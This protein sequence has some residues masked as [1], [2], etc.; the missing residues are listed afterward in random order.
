[1]TSTP[2]VETPLPISGLGIQR[3]VILKPGKDDLQF[4][5]ALDMTA[6]VEDAYQAMD[7]VSAIADREDLKTRMRE[8]REAL[9]VAKQQPAQMQKDIERLRVQR[10][11][12]LAARTAVHAAS[13]RRSPL[14]LTDKAQGDLEKFDEQI[15]QAVMAAKN[16]SRDIPII[17]WEIAC[18][19]A[20]IDGREPPEAPNEVADAIEDLKNAA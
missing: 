17:E 3:R 9:E 11:A 10:A 5:F 20:K 7:F 12:F 4:A 19:E 18:L 8:K 2:T 13:G 16:F 6:P 15:A 14:K 1:M